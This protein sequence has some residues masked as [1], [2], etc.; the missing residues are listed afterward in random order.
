VSAYRHFA[1][2]AILFVL[3]STGCGAAPVAPTGPV[4]E[5]VEAPPPRYAIAL[6]FE[7]EDPSEDGTPRTRVSLVRI[8][9]EGERGVHALRAEL[10]A[11][12]YEPHPEALTAGVCW[13][14]GAG[15]RYVI[16]RRGGEVVALRA[17]ADEERGYGDLEELASV[18]VPEDAELD[19]L[20][21]R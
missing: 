11:C 6:R 1:S 7:E 9:P 4:E 17:E 8:T 15:A 21:A 5:S 12:Y 2:L 20:G 16:L 13:W 19:V 10:G 3:A 18:E 14:A